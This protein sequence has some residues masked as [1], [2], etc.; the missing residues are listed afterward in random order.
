MF[1]FFKTAVFYENPINDRQSR[2][3]YC[4]IQENLSFT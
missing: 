2:L 4:F 3:D 1:L